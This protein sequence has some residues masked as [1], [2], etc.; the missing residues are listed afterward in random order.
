MGAPELPGWPTRDDSSHKGDFGRVTIVGG[1]RG[2]AG[3]VL[4]SGQ[5]ALRGGSGLVTVATIGRVADLLALAEPPLLTRPLPSDDDGLIGVAQVSGL[6]LGHADAVACGPGLGQSDRLERLVRELVRTVPQPLV[7]DADALN[8]VAR[9]PAMLSGRVGP[10]VLT[11]HPGEFSRLTGRPIA[12][13]Q[14]NRRGLA[15]EFA[16][17]FGVVV[18]LKGEGTIV[19]DGDRTARNATGNVG[20][21]TAGT[22]DVLTGLVASLLG[23]G[24]A[25]WPAARLAVHLH[26]RAGDLGAEEVGTA[27]L[28][29]TVLRDR[30][31]P[32][33]VEHRR[34]TAAASAS[35]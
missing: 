3:S 27:S 11:P 33:I 26:G 21:A 5:A 4:L 14:K 2:M 20:M 9:E 17:R 22:G 35:P 7:L 18:V 1:S 30:L 31:A 32:A 8:L 34:Q 28:T 23:Q 15:E 25:A 12:D 24:M 10:T 13:V 29:A 19:T 16:G 6:S